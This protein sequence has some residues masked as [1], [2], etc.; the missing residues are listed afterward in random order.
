MSK[1]ELEAQKEEDD[2]MHI[3]EVKDHMILAKE[4]RNHDRLK[5]INETKYTIG[6]MRKEM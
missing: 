5:R 4:L 1:Y 6:C 2:A 3:K